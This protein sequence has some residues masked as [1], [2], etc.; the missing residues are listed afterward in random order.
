MHI[1]RDMFREYDIR[2]IADDDLTEEAAY[3]IARAFAKYAT[4]EGQRNMFVGA[5]NRKSSPKLREAVIKGLTDS[6][7]H[8]FDLGT[9]I[10]PL[11]YHA[12]VTKNVPAGIMVTASHNPPQYNG[13]KL[14]LGEGTLYGDQI[15]HIAD[16]VEHDEF[17]NSKGDVE[18]YDHREEYITDLLERIGTTIPLHIGIDC[19]NGTA[20]LFAPE[21][22]NRAGVQVEPLY[23]D[24]DPNFPHHQPDPVKAEN[25]QDLRKLVLDKHLD[26][27]LG[28][29]GDGDRIGVVDD[30]GNILF[31]DV[32]MVLFW[33]EV[34]SKRDPKTVKA[35]VEVKCSEALV[36]ELKRMGADVVMY[37][38]G[39]SLIK[40]K[41]REL[42][43]PFAGEMSGHM[44]FAD[45]YYGFDDALYSGLRLLRL[46]KQSGQ[47]LS[48]L[49]STIPVYHASPEIRL[50]YNDEKKFQ[51]VEFVK[52]YF[53]E[54]GYKLIDVD[55][56][57][58]Y[59]KSGWGLVRASNTGPEIIVRY[60]AKNENDL[61]EIRQE[62]VDALAAGGFSANL[63]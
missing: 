55:G 36:E 13:F 28:F 53:K 2:G 47:K 61:P 19:G 5:D 11:F 15:Q 56:V 40:A 9:V 22:F 23:C 3:A 59:I 6:G 37:K 39:H 8:V 41:M 7:I 18:P 21:L 33:R 34:L 57:R 48:D 32:L 35:I 16:M 10:T 38:T 4:Q 30:K 50:E 27:G 43:S 42:K 26:F 52:N 24:S 25:M 17:V 12:C 45:E 58:V 44:F 31:G 54:K 63:P 14:F 62:L 49:V 20:S 51:L 1:N 29:D 46:V 60:E